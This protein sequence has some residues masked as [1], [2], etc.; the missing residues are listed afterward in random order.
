VYA[1]LAEQTTDARRTAVLQD[2][3]ERLEPFAGLERFQF[4]GIG[5]S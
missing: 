3:V 1:E 5:W 2:L 4:A